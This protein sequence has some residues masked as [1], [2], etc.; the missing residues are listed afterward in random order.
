VCLKSGTMQ[1]LAK[2]WFGEKKWTSDL[3][4]F[5]SKGEKKKEKKK[6]NWKLKNKKGEDKPR[7]TS[8]K[9]VKKPTQLKT[10][11]KGKA[12]EKGLP[13]QK[14]REKWVKTRSTPSQ[15]HTKNKRI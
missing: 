5:V 7:W 4:T 3:G 2:K 15:N 6:E 13:G 12:E 10:R 14:S 8:D 9:G 11:G 1:K